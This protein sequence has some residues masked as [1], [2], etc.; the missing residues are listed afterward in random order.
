M[1][2]QFWPFVFAFLVEAL[3]QTTPSTA[4]AQHNDQVSL[5]LLQLVNSARLQGNIRPLCHSH[6]LTLAA[7]SHSSYQS[8]VNTM[9]HDSTISLGDRFLRQGYQP[10]SVAENVGFTSTPFA[11]V[12]FDIWMGSPEHRK[13]I[14]DPQYVHFGAASS[15][16]SNGMYYWTQLF[17]SPM[18][19]HLESC[20]FAAA[21]SAAQFGSTSMN[22][23]MNDGQSNTGGAV[24]GSSYN[25]YNPAMNPNSN[26]IMVDDGMGGKSLSCKMAGGGTSISGING[27][28]Y[29]QGTNNY[30][31]SGQS[32]GPPN[33]QPGSYQSAPQSSQSYGQ[34]GQFNGQPSGQPS[35]YQSGAQSNSYQTSSSYSQNTPQNGQQLPSPFNGQNAP[36]NN[37]S[38]SYPS[39]SYSGNSYPSNSNSGN[40]NPSNPMNSYQSQSSYNPSQPGPSNSPYSGC[41]VIS[42]KPAP[43]GQGSVRVLSCA[44]GYPFG[45]PA[46]GS[47]GQLGGQLVGNNDGFNNRNA[48][49][50]N[51]PG[52]GTPMIINSDS[53][54]NNPG[55]NTYPNSQ[56]NNQPNQ[57]AYGSSGFNSFWTPPSMNTR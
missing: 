29:N 1:N 48:N 17:A 10:Q 36:I 46:V 9:T 15:Q 24:Y 37:P 53:V 27:Q 42:T 16:G 57:P 19:I 54:L 30:G 34:P 50:Y 4:D 21:A 26:C 41:Q 3:A 14:L 13:N 7:S 2:F 25:A 43:D 44:P 18:N 55:Y 12:V 40:S 28:N 22:F 47:N 35:S 5:Q 52:M 11:Q 32:Y 49:V 39:N 23:N 20:D 31:Q 56:P 8:S 33:G 45:G 6:K 38:S 51:S